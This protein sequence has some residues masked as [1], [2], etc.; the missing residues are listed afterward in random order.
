MVRT[1]TR[2]A[3][4]SNSLLLILKWLDLLG[5]VQHYL[6]DR[7]LV[8]HVVH[9]VQII[10]AIVVQAAHVVLVQLVEHV[11]RQRHRLLLGT[12]VSIHQLQ[13]RQVYFVSRTFTQVIIS[14]NVQEMLV[15]GEDF[16]LIEYCYQDFTLFIYNLHLY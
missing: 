14:K 11:I 15:L 9:V 10:G 2:F 12:V 4:C 16:H 5:P 1:A 3:V 8:P 13:T 7:L 6:L